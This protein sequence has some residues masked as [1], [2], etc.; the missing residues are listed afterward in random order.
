[1]DAETPTELSRAPLTPDDIRSIFIGLMLVMFLSALDGTI[2]ATAMPT[3]GR[4][5]GDTEHLAW[6]VTAYLLASTAVT[7][8][9]GK[10][11]DMYG[12]RVVLLAAVVI[13]VAGSV[14]CGLARSMLALALGRGLQGLGGGGLIALAQTI[15]ADMVTPRERGRYQGYFGTVFATASVLGPMLGGFFAENL[16]WSWIFWINIPLGILGYAMTNSRLKRLPR[17]ERRHRLDILG[18]GLM[19]GATASLMLA[20]NWGGAHGQ[21]GSPSVLALFATS[22]LLWPAFVFR[23]WTAREPLIPLSVL[24]NRVVATGTLAASLAMGTYVGLTITIPIYFETVL[25]LSARQSGLALLPFMVTVPI[26]ATISGRVMAVVTHY[27]RMPFVGLT[28]TTLSIVGLASVS[29]SRSL[30]AIE[31]CL[32]F[33][34]FGVGTLFPVTTVSVQ[35]AVAGHYLGTATAAMN[36]SRQLSGAM[37]VAIFGAIALGG[38]SLERPA[39]SHVAVDAGAFTTVFWTASAILATSLLVFLLMPETPLRDRR[40]PPA[41]AAES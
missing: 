39:G 31:L 33:A 9:Y 27:K 4:D 24:G 14:A 11:S 36:F 12:R 26:G 8:L 7:P 10:L 13:F 28:L 29:G 15:I 21:W 3:I 18:S 38:I 35:N 2:V 40:L 41:K 32:F 1:M 5:L 19:I 16:H 34:S 25:G 30:P 6:I 22:A 17:N 23:L 20:L 37:I